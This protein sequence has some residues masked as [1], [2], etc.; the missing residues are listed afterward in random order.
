MEIVRS[1]WEPF[2]GLDATKIDWDSEPVR[3]LVEQR[4]SPDVELRWSANGPE[5]RVYR[6]REGVLDAFREWVEPFSEYYTEALDFIG[7]GDQV[8]VPQSQR[9][10]GSGSGVPVEIEV[11]HVYLFRDDQIARVDEYETLE[12]ALAAARMADQR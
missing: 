2:N 10:V 3:E 4:Y 12:E 7:V 11:T 9:G 6:G 1:M 8:V 5:T